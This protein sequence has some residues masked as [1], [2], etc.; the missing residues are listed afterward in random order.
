MK[1]TKILIATFFLIV[2]N[3]VIAQEKQS[4]A[5]WEETINFLVQNSAYIDDSVDHSRNGTGY[6]IS[7]FRIEDSVLYWTVNQENDSNIH[8]QQQLPLQKL[9]KCTLEKEAVSKYNHP[10]TIKLKLTGEYAVYGPY[11]IDYARFYIDDVEMRPR[12]LKAFQHLTFLATEK[13]KK[14]REASAEKF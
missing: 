6:N 5:T 3:L 7:N 2:T 13:R 14:E 4:D 1:R 10:N 12:I 8:N 9:L 11:T